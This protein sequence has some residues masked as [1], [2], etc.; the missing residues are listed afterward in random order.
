MNLYKKT[1]EPGM[2]SHIISEFG[3]LEARTAAKFEANVG[4][5]VGSSQAGFYIYITRSWGQEWKDTWDMTTTHDSKNAPNSHAE[6]AWQPQSKNL[7]PPRHRDT[8][9]Q[10]PEL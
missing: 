1:S 6:G 9:L 3:S 8:R 4:Y 2:V 7:Y 10:L 5:I